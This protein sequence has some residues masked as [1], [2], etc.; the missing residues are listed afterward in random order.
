M[1]EAHDLLARLRDRAD[2]V[3]APPVGQGKVAAAER[4]LGFTLPPLLSM[5]YLEVSDGGFGP[6]QDVPIP[7][8]NTALLYSLDKAVAAYRAARTPPDASLPV[9][10]W[11]EGVLP[12]LYWGCFGHAAVDCRDDAAPVVMF[13]EDRAAEQSDGTWV[14]DEAWTLDAPNL[15]IWWERWLNGV[16]ASTSNEVWTGWRGRL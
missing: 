8:Y 9:W 15:A 14:I 3:G 1:A 4:E 6:G 7:G 13:E 5:V 2:S 10:P 11:P 12:L 16:R